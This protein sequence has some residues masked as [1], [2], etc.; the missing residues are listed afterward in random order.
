MIKKVYSASIFNL[1]K[2]EVNLNEGIECK[3]LRF[4]IRIKT[5]LPNEL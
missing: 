2:M 3:K 4:I 1:D 5:E